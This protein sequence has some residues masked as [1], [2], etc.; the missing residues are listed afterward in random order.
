MNPKNIARLEAILGVVLLVVAVFVYW[1]VSQIYWIAVYPQP[2]QKQVLNVLPYAI[3][4]LGIVL[5]LDA[6]RRWKLIY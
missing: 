5:L 2:F 6:I 1:W 4:G 3:A